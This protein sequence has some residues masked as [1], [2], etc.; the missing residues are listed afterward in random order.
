MYQDFISITEW[1]SLKDNIYILI[2][3][4]S[5]GGAERQVSLLSK[6]IGISKIILL[7]NVVMYETEISRDILSNLKPSRSITETFKIPFY[8]FKLLKLLKNKNKPKIIISFLVRSNLIN[9]IV[10]KILGYKVIISERNTPSQI[11]KN[12]LSYYYGN[13][14]KYCYPFADKIIVNSYGIQSDL[15][16][17]YD[18][19]IE[20]IE[21]IHNAIDIQRIDSLKIESI[22]DRF[23]TFFD[24]NDI[25]IN[26]GSLTKQKGQIYLVKILN[27]LKIEG[28][29]YKLVIIGSGHLKNNLIKAAVDLKLNVYDST[30]DHGFVKNKIDIL[31][32]NYQDNPYK[33]I[34]LS[35]IFLFP[36]LWEGFPNVLLEAMAC[37]KPI[38]SSDCMSGP[39]EIL[40]SNFGDLWGVNFAKFAEFGILLPLP[41][42]ET[43]DLWVQVINTLFN[44]DVMMRGYS[45][46][47]YKRV[48]SF[49]KAKIAKQWIDMINE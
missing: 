46:L 40:T 42:N 41:K 36:S 48:Y 44:D 3:S 15:V 10:G 22:E 25:L 35:K 18:I 13:L 20:K 26:V 31:F 7:N 39:K 4:L 21:V 38:I 9:I 28:K 16:K 30:L 49:D 6:K 17:N 11:Y 24:E 29:K 37:K 45:K 33:Y 1:I 43:V 2:N 23:K 34:N 32:L 8:V 14:I 5:G 27:K 47:G 19:N 12:G